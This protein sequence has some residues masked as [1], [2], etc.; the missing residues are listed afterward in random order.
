LRLAFTAFAI[1]FV[2]RS[3]AQ[4]SPSLSLIKIEVRN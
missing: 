4:R 3:L 2:E 1:V